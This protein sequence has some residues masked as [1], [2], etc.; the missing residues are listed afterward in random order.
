MIERGGIRRRRGE[1]TTQNQSFYAI[2]YAEMNNF[3][4]LPPQKS[5]YHVKNLSNYR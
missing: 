3:L 2:L 1:Y 5:G 4:S